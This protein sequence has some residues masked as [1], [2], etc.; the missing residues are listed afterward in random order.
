MYYGSSTVLS[1]VQVRKIRY[2]KIEYDTA[3]FVKSTVLFR[4]DDK[5][6]G[7]SVVIVIAIRML[8]RRL[9]LHSLISFSSQYQKAVK[10]SLETVYIFSIYVRIS[11]LN[12]VTRSPVKEKFMSDIKH[13][14]EKLP[15]SG[16]SCF[17]LLT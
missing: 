5:F 3:R 6:G 14:K 16:V 10:T 17:S 15:F 13:L 2:G 12:P 9:F 7:R 1:T 4:Y 8:L 11:E